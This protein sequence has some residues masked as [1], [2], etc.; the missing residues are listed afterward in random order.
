MTFIKLSFTA[1]AILATFTIIISAIMFYKEK[2]IPAYIFLGLSLMFI[3]ILMIIAKLGIGSQEST[4]YE[5]EDIRD[6]NFV[7]S[8]V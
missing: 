5:N 7:S 6:T 3:L 2:M 8:I 4:I 1:C